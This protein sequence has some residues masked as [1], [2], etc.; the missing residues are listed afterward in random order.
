M[1]NTKTLETERL[2]LRKFNIE[3]A[4]G[5]FNNWATDSETNKFLSW[6]LHSNVDETK[7]VISKW[8]SNYESG[9]YNWIVETKDTHEVIGSICEEGKSVKHKTISLGYCYGSKYW[10]KGYAS[11][12]LRRVIE[13]LL[14]E[15]DFYLVEAN[16]RSSNPASGRVMEKAGMKYEGFLRKRVVDKEGNRNN[17]LVYSILENEYYEID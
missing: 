3:D 9:S 16:H 17:L 13:Y 4:E 14:T 6:P 1:D 10:N 5:M 2:I 11:E 8:I 15:Q 12:V 7:S